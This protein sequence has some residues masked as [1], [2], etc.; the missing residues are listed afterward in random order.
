VAS[1]FDKQALC[2]LDDLWLAAM[3]K[4]ALMLA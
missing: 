3:H 2:A 1:D 4:K